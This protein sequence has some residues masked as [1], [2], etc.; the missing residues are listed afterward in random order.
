M[1]RKLNL[2]DLKELEASARFPMPDVNSD[3]TFFQCAIENEEGE[4][5]G[6]AFVKKTTEVSLIFKD[7]LSPYIVS[8][9]ILEVWEPI[10]IAHAAH[11]FDDTHVF[12]LGDDGYFKQFLRKLGFVQATGTPLYYKIWSRIWPRASRIKHRDKQIISTTS[13]RSSFSKESS[14]D[15]VEHS[16]PV[17]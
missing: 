14:A 5:I 1:I 15:Q 16:V 11:G 2:V 9:G 13:L 17:D 3:L 12:L 4:L 6:A 10:E 8:K 7:D